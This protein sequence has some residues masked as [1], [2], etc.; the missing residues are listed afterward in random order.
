MRITLRMRLLAPT[1]VL[2][3]VVTFTVATNGALART[4]YDGPWNV[5]ITTLRGACNSGVGF[6][7][8]IRDGVVY[9]YGSFVVGGRVARNGAVVVRIGQGGSSASG[10]GHLSASSGG[11]TW[12]GAGSRGVCS[13]RWSA[14]RK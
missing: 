7:V 10:T 13:G 8:E 1:G 6:G 14:S 3:A 9:G 11:G 5:S 12:R 2:S 4:P